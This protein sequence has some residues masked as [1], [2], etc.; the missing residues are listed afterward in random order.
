MFSLRKKQTL[1]MFVFIQIQSRW[2]DWFSYNVNF[3]NIFMI[4]YFLGKI[5]SLPSLAFLQHFQVLKKLNNKFA[6][7]EYPWCKC[8]ACKHMEEKSFS[9]QQFSKLTS[10]AK[11]LSKFHKFFCSNFC[12]E[13]F[14]LDQAR[15]ICTLTI[16]SKYVVCLHYSD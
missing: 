14:M 2:T 10:L 11:C 13:F 3:L 16:V 12:I 15:N 6:N 1:K 7:M 5:H 8:L 4:S 9:K